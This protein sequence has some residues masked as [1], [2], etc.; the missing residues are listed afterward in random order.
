MSKI[1]KTN[2]TKKRVNI[3]VVLV[4]N[5][6]KK[7]LFKLIIIGVKTKTYKNREKYVFMISN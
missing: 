7:H 1:N 2:L 4:T 6:S 5:P 3:V